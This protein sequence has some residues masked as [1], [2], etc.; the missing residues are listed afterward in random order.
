MYCR[1]LWIIAAVCWTAGLAFGS[2]AA[3]AQN[4]LKDL[5]VATGHAINNSGHVALDQ[6]IYSNGTITPLPAVP[7][8]STPAAALAI[9]ASGQVAG[10]G[11]KLAKRS[12]G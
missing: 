2:A 12:S 6:G 8:G 5:G 10:S 11:L 3:N 7:G 4:L 9:N 1:P